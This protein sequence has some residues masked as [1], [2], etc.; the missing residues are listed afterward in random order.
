[1]LDD[2]GVIAHH[3]SSELPSLLSSGDLVVAN[4]AATLPASLHGTHVRSGAAI[5]VRLA[6]HLSRGFGD[7]R[8]FM[9]VVFGAG[10]YRTPTEHRPEPPHLRGGD[11]IHLGSLRATIVAVHQHPRLVSVRFDHSIEEVWEGLARRGRPIQYAYVQGPLAIWD[12]WTSIAGLPA[13]FE[14]P[15]AGFILDWAMLRTFRS[16]GVQ[17]ATLTHAAGISSTGDDELDR[18]LPFDEAYVIP[19][20]TAA[21]VQ[22]TKECGGR[23]IAVGTTVVRALEGAGEGGRVIGGPGVATGRIGSRITLKIVDAI[24]SGVHEPG[25]SHY[26]LLRAFQN[27]EHLQQMAAIAAAHDYRIHEFGDSVFIANV[28]SSRLKAEATRQVA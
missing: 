15:S 21:L 18:L 9:A 5:E 1:V 14:A 12:T 25:T 28:P 6:G 27:D 13:A 8:Q 10:D 3:R 16:R 7:V 11:Q 19:E 23:V 22:R 20:R 26:E 2:Q 24:V 17:F 4:D